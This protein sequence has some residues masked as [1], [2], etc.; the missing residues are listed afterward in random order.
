VLIILLLIIQFNSFRYALLILATLPLSMI[1]AILGLL[2]T[3]NS[4]GF[5]AF[6]GVVSLCGVV[7][8]NA[9]VLLDFVR[10]QINAGHSARVALQEAGVRRMRPILL[11]TMTT[12]GGLIPLLITGG[13]MWNGMAAVLIFGLLVSTLLT[14]LVIPCFYLVLVGDREERER[15]ASMD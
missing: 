12:V 1:G 3:F 11:T 13:A 9:I 8:N 14:L 15:T 6:L 2:V 4:F 5:M 7:V 10:E